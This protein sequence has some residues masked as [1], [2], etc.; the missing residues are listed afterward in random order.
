M[1]KL[2]KPFVSNNLPE[3]ISSDDNKFKLFL[4]AYYEFLEKRNDS[5]AISVKEKFKSLHNPAG[6]INNLTD[7]KSIDHTLD[8]YFVYFKNELLPIAIDLAKVKDK[9]LLK[10]IRDVYLSKGSQKSFELLFRMIY[11]EDIDIYETRDNILEASEGKF[12]SFPLVT[13]KVVNNAEKLDVINFVLADISHSDSDFVNDSDV[14][15]SLSGQVL[16]KTGDSDKQSVIQLQL[17]TLY[18]FDTS[19]TY[20]ITD[21]SNSTVFIDVIPML[22]LVDIKTVTNAPGYQEGDIIKVK[23]IAAN[24]TLNII[25]DSVNSGPVTGFHFRDRGEF[26]Q[27]N[28]LLSFEPE[29]PGE[30]AGGSALISGVDN[31]GRITEIDGFKVRTGE[32]Y[33]GFLSDDFENVIVPIT[34]GGTYRRL[35]RVVYLP[36]DPISSGNPYIKNTT[37]SGQG[38]I[39]TPISDTIG[40]I[41][42]LNIFDRGYFNSINDVE[43]TA[44]MNL[45]LEEPTDFLEGQVVSIQYIIPKGE[46]FDND[47]DRLDISIK[48]KKTVNYDSD[49]LRYKI[50]SITLPHDFDSELFQWTDSEYTIDSDNGLSLIT[51]AWKNKVTKIDYEV[52]KDSDQGFKVRLY[53]RLI[54]RLDPYHFSLLDKYVSNDSDYQFNYVNDYADP[55]LGIDSEI[56]NFVNSGFFGIV[57]R[58]SS[59]KK[60]ISISQYRN[61]DFP[62]DSDLDNLDVPKNRILRVAAYDVARDQLRITNNLPTAS[63]IAYHSRARFTPVLSAVSESTKTFINEDGFLNS[64]S[65][66]VVQDNYLY[67]NFTYIIQSNLSIDIW[68]EKIKTTLH[69][70][71]MYLF[72]ETNFNMQAPVNVVPTANFGRET[73]NAHFTYDTTLDYYS[74]AKIYNRVTADNT[75]YEANSFIFYDQIDTKMDAL[76]ASSFER[77]SQEAET[78]ETGS[79]WFDFEPLGLVRNEE[80]NYDGFYDSYLNYDSE[81]LLNNI[82][83]QDSDGNGYVKDVIINYKKFNGSRQDLY[84]RESRTRAS[85]D[86]VQTMSTKLIDPVNDLYDVYDS[87]LP[88]GFHLRWSDSDNKTFKAI[89][90]GRLKSEN[91]DTRT[92]KWY[93][94]DRKKELMFKK[95]TDLN[96]AMR[97]DGTFTFTEQDGTVLKDIEAYERKWNEIN[98][99][100]AD[101]EGWEVNGFSSFIQNMKQKPRFLF[102]KYKVMRTPDFRKLKTPFKFIVWD[103]TDDSDNIIWGRHYQTGEDAVLN[104]STGTIYDWYFTNERANLEEWRDP[105]SSMKGRKRDG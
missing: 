63:I 91:N 1:D 102:E 68:R 13:F 6:I 79:S 88:V 52:M 33:N 53:N 101:S 28:D 43:I 73:F 84:K 16:G 77:G 54:N 59:A 89:D 71:G 25:V 103:K 55:K 26:Y 100:R 99:F 66:G 39:F 20:R 15:V 10:K 17:N 9:F 19:Q 37:V 18:N 22:S 44:P 3:F 64:A 58:I 60:V 76:L 4:E 12:L 35:P 49:D 21:Q 24:K 86:P 50:K 2:V 11:D 5:D 46:A 38:A 47:S 104:N 32:L 48:A 94:T 62:S 65:G 96:S 90:Y 82:S 57:D 92:F 36:N 97:L 8:E 56:A 61:N 81:E 29:V 75:R 70:A 45:V 78:A 95:A 30:G 31:H 14:A 67:S 85:Y 74:D 87:D 51:T 42:K 27:V 83:T 72:G 40:T 80:V 41:A 34:S 7:Y 23:S 93:N 105:L 69:P 98:S